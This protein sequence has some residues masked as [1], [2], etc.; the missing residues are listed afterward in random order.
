MFQIFSALI[1]TTPSNALPESIGGLFAVILEPGL[2]ET[3]GNVPA[4]ARF[5]SAMI[6]K[7][8]RVI[9]ENG[10]LEKV[11]VL[12]QRLLAGKKT[13][14]DAFNILESAI[15]AFDGYVS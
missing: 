12:F 14:P 5:L 3:R 6:P 1:E 4:C 8:K 10:Q 13:E 15:A 2:W 9:L 7:G 11:L